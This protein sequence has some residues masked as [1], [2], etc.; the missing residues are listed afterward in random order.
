MHIV[1]FLDGNVFTWNEYQ[2]S[3]HYNTFLNQMVPLLSNYNTINSLKKLFEY[4]QI[5]FPEKYRY[6]IPYLLSLMYVPSKAN[7]L[8]VS[9]N[10]YSDHSFTF[11]CIQMS[12]NIPYWNQ[13]KNYINTELNYMGYRGG[14]KKEL[15]NQIKK[16]TNIRLLKVSNKS[17]I[18][19]NYLE[20]IKLF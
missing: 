5:S 2:K 16:S 3:R 20:L 15:N 18:Y 13:I 6:T 11:I 14:G 12:L 19:K 10:I 1:G 9:D 7:I 8:R 17:H 4:N